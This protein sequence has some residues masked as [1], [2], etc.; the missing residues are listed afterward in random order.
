MESEVKDF[1]SN[2]GTGFGIGQRMVMILQ[3]IA[4]ILRDGLQLM[5][6]EPIAQYPHGCPAGTVKPVVR[7]GHP[8]CAEGCFQATLIERAVVRYQRQVSYAGG[9]PPMLHTLE[10][11]SLA[12][13][14]SITPKFSI[15]VIYLNLNNFY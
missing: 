1:N 10:R 14:K 12:V 11:H 4:A 3:I 7:I 2:P 9:A 5:I 13:S 15:L 8:V 6:W